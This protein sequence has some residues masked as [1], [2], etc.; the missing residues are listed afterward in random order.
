LGDL[1]QMV[2]KLIEKP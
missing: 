1:I 2:E